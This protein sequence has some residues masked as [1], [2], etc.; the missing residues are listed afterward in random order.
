MNTKKIIKNIKVKEHHCTHNDKRCFYCREGIGE[1]HSL[2]CVNVRKKVKMKYTF[3][4]EVDMPYSWEK[5]DIEFYR[6]GSS[7]CA[8]NA[9]Q[10]VSEYVDELNKNGDC[11]CSGDRFLAECLDENNNGEPFCKEAIPQKE[12]KD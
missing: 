3:F 9:V 10:E 11:L 1:N 12:R 4:I 6:N 8:D 2:E 5:S 7:S